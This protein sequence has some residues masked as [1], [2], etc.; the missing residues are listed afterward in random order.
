[1]SVEVDE[2]TQE[3]LA[4]IAALEQQNSKLNQLLKDK[5]KSFIPKS[6]DVYDSLKKLQVLRFCYLQLVNSYVW[7]G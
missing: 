7:L 4:R 3:L 5:E 6:A 1:M 2:K